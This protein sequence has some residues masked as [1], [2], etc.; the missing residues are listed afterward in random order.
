MSKGIG[1][2]NSL[3]KKA[4]MYFSPPSLIPD[5]ANVSTCPI[6]DSRLDSSAWVIYSSIWKN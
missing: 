2:R 6:D 3:K 4:Y 1:P 5:A